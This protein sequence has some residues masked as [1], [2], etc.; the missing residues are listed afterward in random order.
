MDKR[1]QASFPESCQI[2]CTEKVG[3]RCDLKLY[4]GQGHGF[5]NHNKFEYYSKT[6]READ[7]FLESLGYLKNKPVVAL[8]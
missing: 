3:S 8:E 7:S 5:F 2:L 4:E 1:E 6:I